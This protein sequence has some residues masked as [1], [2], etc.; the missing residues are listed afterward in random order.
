MCGIFKVNAQSLP[1][2][3]TGSWERYASTPDSL[4]TI[5]TYK[6]TISGA[7]SVVYFGAGNDSI[8]VKWG[9]NPGIYRIGVSEISQFGCAGDYSW[10]FVQVNGSTV[11]IGP[12]QVYCYGDSVHFDAGTD[13]ISYRWNNDSNQTSEF[14]NTIAKQSDTIWVAVTNKYNCHNSDTAIITVNPKPVVD[15]TANGKLFANPNKKDTTM[16][17]AETLTLDAGYDGTIYNWNTGDISESITVGEL[18]PSSPD[19]LKKYVVTVSNQYGCSTSDS[20][21]IIR[22]T[23][24]TNHNIPT[25]FTPDGKNN[26]TWDIEYLQYF[27]NASV[28]VFDRWGRLVYH[29]GKGYQA[30]DGTSNG[31]KVP[32]DAYFYIIKIDNNTKPIIGNVTVIR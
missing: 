9:Q 2:A 32:M 3:C 11:N 10:A 22:C 18:D 19:S 1:V 26:R 25:A 12:D 29:C 8:K 24:P 17:G 14:Y 7:D 5:S 21:E 23:M 6:W 4:F 30:W 15:I 31:V 28:D 27:P 20:V 13:F 16:C